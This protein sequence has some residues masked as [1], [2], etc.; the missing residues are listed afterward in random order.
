MGEC[1]E[2]RSGEKKRGNGE[3]KRGSDSDKEK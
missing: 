3:E 2:E 1:G